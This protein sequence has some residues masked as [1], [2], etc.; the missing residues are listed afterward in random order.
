MTRFVLVRDGQTEWSRVECFRG[1]AD[2]PLNE[3]GLVQAEATGQHVAA[4]WAPIAVYSSPLS[5]T[6][7]T[8]EAI[9]RYF[10]LPGQ[11]YPDLVDI[12]YGGWQSLTPEEARRRDP[13][14]MDNWC[15]QPEQ[16]RI[17]GGE[18]LADQRARP[19]KP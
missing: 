11:A 6:V 12:D 18:T 1:R 10:N 7:K 3:T 2:M 17:P 8:A 16:A 13:E 14:P 9:A 15:N 19:C 5:H 4:E